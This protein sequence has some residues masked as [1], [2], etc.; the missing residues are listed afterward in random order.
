[1][2]TAESLVQPKLY[3]LAAHSR[4]RPQIN[5]TDSLGMLIMLLPLDFCGGGPF[6]F[7]PLFPNF[8][9]YPLFFP[10]P[11]LFYFFPFPSFFI[12]SLSLLFS[13]PSFFPFPSFTSPLFYPLFSLFS[14]FSLSSLSL[15][16]SLFFFPPL[17]PFCHFFLF[18]PF[19]L[20]CI[21]G[22]V[23]VCLCFFFF[24]RLYP[25]FSKFLIFPFSSSFGSWY[26]GCFV[27]S[28]I[29]VF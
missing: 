4:D 24:G 5:V 15:L 26:P 12:F 28:C 1:M 20:F 3:E 9:L 17:V 11:P 21:W 25:R 22:C 10:F 27:F 6:L 2:T 7:L 13:L 29:L 14:L 23:C 8:Y 18:F 19:T 16:F